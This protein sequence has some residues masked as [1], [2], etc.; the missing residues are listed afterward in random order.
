[1]LRVFPTWSFIIL[2]ILLIA[3]IWSLSLLSLTVFIIRLSLYF[4]W[5]IPCTTYKWTVPFLSKITLSLTGMALSEGVSFN[6]FVFV[7]SQISNDFHFILRLFVHSRCY[8]F[9]VKSIRFYKF[10]HFLSLLATNHALF[11]GA[12][13]PLM[14]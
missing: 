7:A 14:L 8:A 3:L 13:T 9:F 1:M 4:H 2:K 11:V 6:P 5:I 10:L 12:V